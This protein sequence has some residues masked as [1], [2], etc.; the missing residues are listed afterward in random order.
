MLNLWYNP[1]LPLEFG[2]NQKTQQEN[3][4]I[5]GDSLVVMEKTFL[6]FM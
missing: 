2:E 6:I 3:R 5:G 1:S 4:V